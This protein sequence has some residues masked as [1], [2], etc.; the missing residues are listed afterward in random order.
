MH[1]W[2]KYSAQGF[3]WLCTPLPSVTW[4]ISQQPR[5]K[6]TPV[7][8]IMHLMCWS[9]HP[10]LFMGC[11]QGFKEPCWKPIAIS[12]NHKEIMREGK[13]P[14]SSCP[15]YIQSLRVDKGKCLES[16]CLN[17]FSSPSVSFLYDFQGVT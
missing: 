17:S 16:K 3:P 4:C 12:D 15:Q 8:T 1:L 10:P 13:F 14:E 5:N 11:P 7:A 9:Q 2:E 6:L